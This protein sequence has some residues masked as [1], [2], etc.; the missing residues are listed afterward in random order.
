MRK[1]ILFFVLLHIMNLQANAVVEQKDSTVMPDLKN[2][3]FVML[4]TDSVWR[5]GFKNLIKSEYPKKGVFRTEAYYP[6]IDSCHILCSY[7]MIPQADGN[8]H[9]NLRFYF[10]LKI[11]TLT[12]KVQNTDEWKEVTLPRDFLKKIEVIDMDKK[13]PTLKTHVE[14]FEFYS[15]LWQKVVW[16]I[17]RRTM[18]DSTITLVK[19]EIL[20]ES[21]F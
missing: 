2:D 6:D 8:K 10:K 1:I 9:L 11:D 20:R 18:T 16:I 4:T 13:L 17:D 5:V 15:S 3:A 21:H 19:T 14:E 7:E 12:W